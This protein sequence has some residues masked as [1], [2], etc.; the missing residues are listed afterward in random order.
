MCALVEL[1]PQPS[2]I[3]KTRGFNRP[4]A[5]SCR[6]E[7]EVVAPL[8]GFGN[9]SDL[10]G[11]ERDQIGGS[12]FASGPYYFSLKQLDYRPFINSGRIG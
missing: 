9:L 11:C 2:N 1:H 10:L 3:T 6:V 8:K 12:Y 4:P 7:E 5:E